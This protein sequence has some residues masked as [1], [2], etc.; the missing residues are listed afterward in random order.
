MSDYI[1][2]ERN[3][4][5]EEIKMLSRYNEV[6]SVALSRFRGMNASDPYV[7]KQTDKLS[8]SVRNRE[9]EIEDFNKRLRKLDAGELDTELAGI[10]QQNRNEAIEKGS[11]TIKRKKE[12]K[13]VDAESAKKSKDFYQMERK[14][15]REGK[16]W[17]YKSA[18]R[19]FFKTCENI[20]DWM[21]RDLSKMPANE[22]YIW[23]NV[24][25]FG[26]RPRRSD[27]FKVTEANKGFKIIRYWDNTHER[28]CKK[29]GRGAEVLIS[30]KLRKKK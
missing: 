10:M 17:L 28:I 12:A 5:N 9:I 16:P 1:I 27:L 19:H 25:C 21:K 8:E 22:G 24:Y 23:K 3:R 20:P 14:G 11:A 30:T 6:D 2:Y 7:Q 29:E 26:D 4:I 13:A 15:N 18:E